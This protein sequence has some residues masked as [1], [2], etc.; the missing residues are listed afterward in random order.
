MR[1]YTEV[2]INGEAID[3]MEDL[4]IPINLINPHLTY[5]SIPD[6]K[7]SVPNIPF[8]LHNQHI[9]EFAEL[10]QAGNDLRSY[11]CE[12][13]YNGALVYRGVA[14]V[15]SANPQTGYQLEVGDDLSRFFGVFQNLPLSEIDLGTVTLPAT[16][17][18]SVTVT[19]V[20]A[21]CFPTIINPDYYG[22]NGS[23]ISYTGLINQY[24]APGFATDR[25]DKPVVP[26]LFVNFLLQ[27][28]ALATGI[29][30]QGSFL[31]NSVWSKLILTNWRALDGKTSVIVN[32]HVPSWTIPA[33]LL[34]LRKIPN[35]QF[36]FNNAEKKL[37]IDFWEEKLTTAPMADWTSK[38]VIGH[39]KY[40]EFNRRIHLAF[41]LDGADSLMK[42][43]PAQM[44]DYTTPTEAV[45]GDVA[46]GLAKITMKLSTFIVDELTGLPMAKQ[47]G[48]TEH[49]N[50]LSNATSPRL[51]FWHGMVED[52]PT[53]L[54]SV[55]QVSLYIQGD[56]GIGETSWNQIESMRLGMFYLKKSFILNEQDLAL[57]DL[58]RQIHCNGLNYLIAHVSGELPIG[59]AFNC[60]LVKV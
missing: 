39:E 57:L 15:K 24:S 14:Y 13:L 50:Q 9:F 21:V 33:F 56:H 26:M 18:G 44:A 54:P 12:V 53:A 47:I 6:S 49:F 7:I 17:P 30:I 36:I 23:S 3:L 45:L 43:K 27:R 19:G 34:E 32:Q 10:P 46:L 4:Q 1:N 28:I 60:L 42:D 2:R 59:K 51:L 8:S 31:E 29:T 40:P 5:E 52:T 38:A 48:V 37:T 41:E 20:P 25:P 16:V 11:D 35:L 22:T 58:G 55:H